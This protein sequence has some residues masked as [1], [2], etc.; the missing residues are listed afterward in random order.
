MAMIIKT[1]GLTKTYKTFEKEE[2]LKG[3]LKALFTKEWVEKI[4]V[5]NF[6]MEINEGEFVGLI[7]QNGAGK[8]TLIKML[9]GIIHPTGGE[10]CVLGFKPFQLKDDFR[11]QYAVVMGQKSQL[12]W[13]LPAMDSFLLNKSIYEIPEK[14]F[15]KNIDYYVELFDVGDLLK[16]QVRNLSLGERMKMELILSL[17]HKPKV[18][19]LD[20]PTIGLDAIAQKQ[21]RLFLKEVNKDKG[22]TIILT[23]HYMEDIK[24]LCKRTIVIRNGSKI[25]DGP[26]DSLLNKYQTHRIVTVMFETPTE[27]L[28]EGNIKWIEKSSYKNVMKVDKNSTKSIVGKLMENYEVA[29]I[30]IEDEEIGEVV[31]RIYKQGEGD[32]IEAVL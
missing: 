2:G 14:D 11:K 21:I 8:T 26:L 13:D 9:T 31:E 12:W 5:S 18:L 25:Y 30:S 28:M 3:S 29:D 16:R 23:S 6:N 20:E 15:R 4:A 7:G 17:M 24:H 27:V 1:M 19:F 32:S 10:V 22:V